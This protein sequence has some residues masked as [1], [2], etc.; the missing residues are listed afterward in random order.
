MGGVVLGILIWE[1]GGGAVAALMAVG[2]V[3]LGSLTWWLRKRKREGKPALLDIAL[4]ASK[5][6]R[7]G[8]SSQTL[9]QVALGGMMIALPIY[10]QMVLE[11]NALEAGLSIAPLSLTMFAV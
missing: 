7:L 9:Q 6:F 4:F 2:A 10:F 8:I 3:S 5:Y 1:E 11:Y